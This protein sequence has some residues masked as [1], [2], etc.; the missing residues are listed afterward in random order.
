MA[1]V[2]GLIFV[3]V[4]LF[5]LRQQDP[6]Q[7][8]EPDLI[9]TAKEIKPS[10]TFI[11]YAD[12]AGFSFSYPDNLS[13]ENN[14]SEDSSDLIDPNA[15]A[16]LQLF[17]KDVSGSLSIKIAD[18]KLKSLDEW[19]KA[20]NI[21]ETT[22]PAEKK[23][24]DLKALEVKTNDR[25]MLASLDQ[26]VLFTVDMPLLEPDFWTKVYDKVLADF[27]FAAPETTNTASV[28][29]ASADEVIFEGEEVVE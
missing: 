5:F 14:A 26:G 29:N 2:L 23:L 28:S 17:S 27:A 1:L 16:D 20:N 18:T 25:I 24:G 22:I 12:P 13:I 6:P 21:P 15:Y 4:F 11:D 7:D 10:E 9:E 19:L 3:G 8:G